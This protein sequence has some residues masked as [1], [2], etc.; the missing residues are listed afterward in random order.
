[1]EEVSERLMGIDPVSGERLWSPLEVSVWLGVSVSTLAY[2]R[3]RDAGPAWRRV[4]R[5][6][7]YDPRDL[8]AWLAQQSGGPGPL[9]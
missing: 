2:W 1:M 9:Q 4:G 7:R 3:H 8:T 5:H 6:V